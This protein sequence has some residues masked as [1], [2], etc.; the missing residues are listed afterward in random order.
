[1]IKLL[2]KVLLEN[3]VRH[4]TKGCVVFRAINQQLLIE[5]Q[6]DAAHPIALGIGLR[7]AEKLANCM[8]WQMQSHTTAK[9]FV[10]SITLK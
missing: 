3:S 4:G 5:N 8:G 1:L 9:H 7:L 2:L 10:I 6:Y